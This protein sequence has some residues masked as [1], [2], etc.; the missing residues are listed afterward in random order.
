MSLEESAFQC[1]WVVLSPTH[2]AKMFI[3]STNLRYL[4]FPGAL[5]VV[6]FSPSSSQCITWDILSFNEQKT[7]YSKFKLPGRLSVKKS[8]G[9]SFQVGYHSPRRVLLICFTSMAIIPSCTHTH[10]CVCSSPSIKSSRYAQG[11]PLWKGREQAPLSNRR[12]FMH[13]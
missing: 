5:S 7:E 12:L 6:V 4:A 2:T 11:R 10:H 1:Q 9:G 8:G 3:Y 13:P